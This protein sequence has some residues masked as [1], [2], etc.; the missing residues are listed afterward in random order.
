MR[1]KGPE[2]L[3]KFKVQTYQSCQPSLLLSAGKVFK[4]EKNLPQ[5]KMQKEGL[6]NLPLFTVQGRFSSLKKSRREKLPQ[7]K[8]GKKDLK[9]SP[10]LKC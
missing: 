5:L 8:L 7:P 1:K 3:P 9:T 4:F 2:N 10:S 6:K